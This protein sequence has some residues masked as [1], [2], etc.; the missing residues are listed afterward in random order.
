M[1]QIPV[2][3]HYVFSQPTVTSQYAN[4]VVLNNY[5]ILVAND[6]HTLA[7][8]VAQV[9]GR[10]GKL[11]SNM[12][13]AEGRLDEFEQELLL[14]TPAPANDRKSNKLLDI[15]VRTLVMGLE[16][17]QRSTWAALREA[18]QSLK[19]DIVVTELEKDSTYARL[20]HLK[21]EADCIKTHLAYVKMES[22]YGT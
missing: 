19:A 12:A 2:N 6:S 9:N 10:L 22:R 15:Y 21:L 17:D 18:I 11:K 8:R 16:D 1:T 3:P 20:N 7:E 4:P 14:K 13:D 5:L